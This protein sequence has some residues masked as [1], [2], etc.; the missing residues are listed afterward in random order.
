M[1]EKQ[2]IYD[3]VMLVHSNKSLSYK[4]LVNMILDKYQ[5]EFRD[6][7]FFLN[8]E[9]ISI[10]EIINV[11]LKYCPFQF[12][13]NPNDIHNR[14]VIYDDIQTILTPN[15]NELISIGSGYIGKG[16]I[17]V[18]GMEAGFYTGDADDLISQPFKPSFF[19]QNTS[20]IL[21]KGFF[22][23]LKSIYFTN[24]SKM[25]VEKQKMNES[26]QENYEKYW[27]ILNNEIELLQPYK[28]L[29]LGANVYDFLKSKNIQCEK[30]YHPSYFIYKHILDHGIEYY[31]KLIND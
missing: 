10:S 11:F 4:K 9:N 31:K 2:L 16:G 5:K 7:D 17:F 26:Y 19:F 28:I 27:P 20:E 6:R 25:A 22:K 1:N 30:I 8:L 3:I 15:D 29:A 14:H 24:A 23:E 13:F 12:S 21:R 18:I